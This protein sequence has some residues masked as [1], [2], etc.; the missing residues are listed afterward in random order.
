V[1]SKVEKEVVAIVGSDVE[2]VVGGKVGICVDKY[3]VGTD[4][5]G[6]RDGMPV[7]GEAVGTIIVGQLDTKLG[8]RVA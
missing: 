7:E 5:V 4:V 1:G 8:F 2:A 6:V 3:A